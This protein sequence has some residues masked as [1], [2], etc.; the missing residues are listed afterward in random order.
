MARLLKHYKFAFF[1]YYFCFFL[2]YKCSIL[3]SSLSLT[4]V[5]MLYQHIIFE[6]IVIYNLNLLFTE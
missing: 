3:A 1:L 6:A 4:I 5:F 2:V